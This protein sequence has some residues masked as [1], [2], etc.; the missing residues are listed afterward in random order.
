MASIK[1]KIEENFKEA[2]KNRDTLRLSTLRMLKAA[3]KNK[4]IE[5]KRELTDQEV[6]RILTSQVKQRKESISAFKEGGRED[7]VGDTEK[8]LSIISEFMPK[9]LSEKEIQEQILKIVKE[10]DAKG[11]KDMGKVMKRAMEVMAGQ[12]DGKLVNKLVKEY[13][14]NL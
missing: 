13:L 8:E 11:M 4:E 10:V 6:L 3:I 5:F 14:S 2:L 12:A 9:Q 1:E 7:L